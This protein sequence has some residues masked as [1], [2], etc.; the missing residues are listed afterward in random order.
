VL[1]NAP[2]CEVDGTLANEGD[3]CAGKLFAH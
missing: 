1:A 3:K 2:Q